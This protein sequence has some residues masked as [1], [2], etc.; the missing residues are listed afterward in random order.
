MGDT[1]VENTVA[2]AIANRTSREKRLGSMVS[3][4]ILGVVYLFL[5]AVLFTDADAQPFDVFDLNVVLSTAERDVST[6]VR[7]ETTVVE[8][9]K[10]TLFR[11][12]G[13]DL[14][15]IGTDVTVG[16]MAWF[17]ALPAGDYFIQVVAVGFIVEKRRVTVGEDPTESE[18]SVRIQLRR[19]ID[20]GQTSEPGTVAPKAAGVRYAFGCN[21]VTLVFVQWQKQNT[22]TNAERQDAL[23]AATNGMNAFVAQ[24]PSEAHFSAN[25]ESRGTYT[26]TAAV[27]DECSEADVWVEDVLGQMGYTAGTVVDKANALATDRAAAVC[28]ASPLCAS[29]GIQNSG[30]LFFIARENAS[31]SP[32]GGWNCH[33]GAYE[34]SY[35]GRSDNE[36]V[37]VHEI[38]HAFGT[39]DEYCTDFGG[40]IGWYCCGWP[41]GN[42]GCD[43]VGGCLAGENGNCEPVC[44]QDCDDSPGVFLDCQDGCPAANCTTQHTPCVMD[45]GAT[46]TFCEFSRR[47]I[48]WVD[49]D[50]DGSLDCLESDCGSDPNRLGSR[51]LASD[52]VGSPYSGIFVD[53]AALGPVYGTE[54]FPYHTVTEGYNA[55]A[56]GQDVNIAGGSYNEQP[57]MTKAVTLKLWGCGNVVIGQ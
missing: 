52:C 11:F 18:V 42:W 1:E 44:G 14:V 36:E 5:V 3:T 33:K 54:L 35:F 28:G 2:C 53:G 32:V 49:S 17:R 23:Q 4:T 25:V 50:C 24:A 20:F 29:C 9:A 19:P 13:D 8:Q 56:P 51:P 7:A 37:Y 55:A 26:V 27:G 40:T 22:W 16:G 34:V 15:R 21:V 30:F 39:T 10:V 57:D 41:G 6:G 48:G 47:Q 46:L 43:A 31:P 45:G 12:E 38:G